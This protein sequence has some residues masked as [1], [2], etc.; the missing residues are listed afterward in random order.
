MS[1]RI[2]MRSEQAV[3]RPCPNRGRRDAKSFGHLVLRQES[4][5]AQSVIAALERIVILDEIDD[6]LPCKQSSVAGA[7]PLLVEYR[8]NETTIIHACR[9]AYDLAFS[10]ADV[11]LVVRTGIGLGPYTDTR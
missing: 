1:V 10:L 7:M 2:R 6:H 3:S 8:R 4:L 5:V 11:L 9:Q